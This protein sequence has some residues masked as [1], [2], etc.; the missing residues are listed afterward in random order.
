MVNVLLCQLSFQNLI[1]HI[2]SFFST[3]G[4]FLD[5]DK[6]DC[7]TFAQ[8]QEFSEKETALLID[9]YKFLGLLPCADN[10]LR[11]IGYW[12]RS[13]DERLV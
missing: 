7:C 8:I 9:R 3:S 6:I 11:A 10:E 1:G 2:D 13:K 4:C 12:V 5:T